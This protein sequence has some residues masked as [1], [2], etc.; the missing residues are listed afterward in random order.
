[1]L[2]LRSSAGTAGVSVRD[3]WAERVTALRKPATGPQLWR[4]YK[5][6]LIDNA[7]DR[8]GRVYADRANEVLAEAAEE[9]L[10][11]PKERSRNRPL[12]GDVSTFH[13]HRSRTGV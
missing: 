13:S 4:L 9:G 8:D 11:K 1:M 2:L 12:A 7:K 6:G 3:G 5:L 10:W